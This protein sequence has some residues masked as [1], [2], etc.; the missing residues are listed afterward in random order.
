MLKEYIIFEDSAH[1][2]VFLVQAED[3]AGA[4]NLYLERE[5][6]YV[7]QPDG[8]YR[9]GPFDYECL[10]SIFGAYGITQ[11]DDGSYSDTDD[12]TFQS[13]E[14]TKTFYGIEEQ[15]D[16]TYLVYNKSYA[17]LSEALRQTVGHRIE[18]AP[19]DINYL[20]PFQTLYASKDK[21][22]YIGFAT[23]ESLKSDIVSQHL[24]QAERYDALGQLEEA[25][26]ELN[27][28][29]IL[30]PSRKEQLSIRFHT[31][32]LLN[33]LGQYPAAAKQY[34]KVLRLA[35]EHDN[36][37]HIRSLLAEVYEHMGQPSKALWHYK[38]ALRANLRDDDLHDEECEAVQKRIVELE[39]ADLATK[40]A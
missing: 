15:A 30:A 28:A 6:N 21:W 27:K 9:G 22:D 17:N 12:K 4:W 34:K 25:V 7:R 32:R 5:H 33:S 14:E 11:H 8:T 2:Q 10:E 19:S 16:G 23:S 31:A 24:W 39:P 3:E 38:Y 26:A 35:T 37:G 36:R 18:I 29:L 40:T 1:A 20:A 13:W